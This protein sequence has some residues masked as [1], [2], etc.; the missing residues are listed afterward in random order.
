MGVR[1]LRIERRM[2]KRVR[3]ERLTEM[4]VLRVVI[5]WS[6][7]QKIIQKNRKLIHLIS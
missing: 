3:P 5:E 2:R 4:L 1:R 7:N 6:L